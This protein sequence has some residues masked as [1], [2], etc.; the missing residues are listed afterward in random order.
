MWLE[1]GERYGRKQLKMYIA[2]NLF[3]TEQVRRDIKE[4]KKWGLY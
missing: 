2:S 4:L 1:N 3:N